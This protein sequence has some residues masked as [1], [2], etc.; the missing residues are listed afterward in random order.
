MGSPGPPHTPGPACGRGVLISRQ[1]R[2]SCPAGPPAAEPR[3]GTWGRGAPTGRR[4]PQGPGAAQSTFTPRPNALPQRGCWGR[5]EVVASRRSG[6]GPV[7]GVRAALF[8]PSPC[9]PHTAA[10]GGR[11][12]VRR[13]TRAGPD[14]T[15]RTGEGG[16]ATPE[17]CPTVSWNT[18]VEAFR[19]LGLVE[20]SSAARQAEAGPGRR[21][22]AKTRPVQGGGGVEVRAGS[23]FGFR[24]GSLAHDTANPSLRAF[25]GSECSSGCSS[26]GS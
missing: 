1:A 7:A 12:S 20:V 22:V 16:P 2:A 5:A 18:V 25:R 14:R 23:R 3:G 21:K 8:H 4:T 17:G 13:G 6:D 26:T 15:G 9:D 10:G 11:G 19:V 24:P